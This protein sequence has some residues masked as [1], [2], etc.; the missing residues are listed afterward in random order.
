MSVPPDREWDRIHAWPDAAIAQ[1]AGRARTMITREQL[2]GLG[3]RPATVGAALARG[4]LHRVHVAVYSLVLPAARPS[5]GA[6]E[7]AV[8]ACGDTAALSHQTAAR[9][10]GLRIDAP[11]QVHLTVVGDRRR[12]GIRVHRT[13]RWDRGEVVRV[14]RLPVTSVARTVIDLSPFVSNRALEHLVDEALRRTSRPKLRAALDR[15]PGRPG[16]GRLRR[17]L[18]P[19]RPNSDTWSDPEEKLLLLVRRAGLPSPEANVP[20]G[21]YFPDLLWREQRVIVEYDSDEFH[22]GERA[23]VDDAARH[24]DLSNDGFSVLHVTRRELSNQPERVL[25]WIGVALARAAVAM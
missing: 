2:L 25:V 4:R 14:E 19:T 21:R 9:L 5:G 8:L 17:L 7:A 1:L 22:S 16:T 20:V 24:N 10:H 18:D 13:L 6:E 12:P 15:H 11:R 23:R 3:V